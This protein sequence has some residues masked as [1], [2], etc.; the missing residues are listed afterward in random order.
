MILFTNALWKPLCTVLPSCMFQFCF[1]LR[2]NICIVVRRIHTGILGVVW[3][4]DMTPWS[5]GG[6]QRNFHQKKGK[7]ILAFFRLHYFLIQTCLLSTSDVT[8]NTQTRKFPLVFL[9]SGHHHILA[10]LGLVKPN[11][12]WSFQ[13]RQRSVLSSLIIQ[14]FWRNLKHFFF[15]TKVSKPR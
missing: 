1:H 3:I 6:L 9:G 7:K 15:L 12:F 2:C 14:S 4:R 13:T 10:C 8:D 5:T 11:S